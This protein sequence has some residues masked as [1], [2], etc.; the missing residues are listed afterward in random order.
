MESNL[1]LSILWAIQICQDHES[2][3]FGQG[4][5]SVGSLGL[6]KSLRGI[7]AEDCGL[8]HKGKVQKP[9]CAQGRETQFSIDNSE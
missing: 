2:G 1:V 3:E 5:L 6:R 7:L 9:G 4:R 8:W